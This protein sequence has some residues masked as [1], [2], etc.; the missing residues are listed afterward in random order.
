M[1]V[2]EYLTLS[3]KLYRSASTTHLRYLLKDKSLSVDEKFDIIRKEYVIRYGRGLSK[4]REYCMKEII[5]G[6][7][8]SHDE[9]YSIG[10]SRYD[11]KANSEL[12]RRLGI[13]KPRGYPCSGKTKT[14]KPC[15][16][17]SKYEGR[18]CH[19]HKTIHDPSIFFETDE[20]D[21]E[22]LF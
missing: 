19:V 12:L 11:I 5:R 14:G 20:Y 21:F 16:N 17:P 7:R 15:R 10:F 2:S 13:W 3:R 6:P 1:R 22:K 4:S 18:K 9:L 8:Q